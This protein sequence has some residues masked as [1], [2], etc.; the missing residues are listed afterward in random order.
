MEFER[1]RSRRYRRH[2][3]LMLRLALQYIVTAV[4]TGC[5]VDR[6]MWRREKHHTRL[7]WESLLRFD[8]EYFRENLCMSKA[9]FVRLAEEQWTLSQTIHHQ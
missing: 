6:I 4:I 2:R 7:T 9:G 8:T 1:A 3:S 5:H